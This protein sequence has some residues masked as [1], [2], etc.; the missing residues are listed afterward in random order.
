MAHFAERRVRKAVE[1]LTVPW[2]QIQIRATIS[3][4][5]ASLSELG[6][7]TTGEAV[8]HLADDRLYKAK[9]GGRNRVVAG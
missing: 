8:L 9:S 6:D 5:V 1:R 4:G 3:V 2:E 7:G